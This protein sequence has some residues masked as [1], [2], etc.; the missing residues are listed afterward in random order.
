M[1]RQRRCSRGWHDDGRPRRWRRRGRGEDLLQRDPRAAGGQK[2]Q[3]IKEVRAI[4]GLGLKEAKEIVDGAPKAVKEGASKEEAEEMKKALEGAGATVKLTDRA[5][6]RAR[7]VRRS[8]SPPR[9]PRPRSGRDDSPSSRS[10]ARRVGPSSRCVGGGPPG[11]QGGGPSSSRSSSGVVLRPCVLLRGSGPVRRGRPAVASRRVPLPGIQ[12]GAPACVGV[13]IR[14]RAPSAGAGRSLSFSGRLDQV[15]S[16]FGPPSPW[17][18]RLGSSFASA[19]PSFP[20]LRPGGRG[21]RRFDL[22]RSPADPPRP[23]VEPLRFPQGLSAPVARRVPSPG[24]ASAS[25]SGQSIVPPPPSRFPDE[26]AATSPG[27][28]APSRPASGPATAPPR[29]APRGPPWSRSGHVRAR[30]RGRRP[31]PPKSTLRT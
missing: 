5:G 12:R 19:P 4:T 10:G 25:R 17:N 24:A 20:C 9:R 22:A 11:A 28:D 26:R 6:A 13:Q 14:C 30:D 31:A 27:R 23:P 1:G 3:V 2:I 15:Q 21:C 29:S 8:R 7:A 18:D 16:T